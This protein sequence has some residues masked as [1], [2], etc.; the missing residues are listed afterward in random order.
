[1]LISEIEDH[2]SF[3]LS[4]IKDKLWLD[5]IAFRFETIVLFQNETYD[6]SYKELDIELKNELNHLIN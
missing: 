6:E 5:L 4:H 2:L 1:M 3:E